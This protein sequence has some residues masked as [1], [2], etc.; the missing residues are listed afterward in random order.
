VTAPL[1]GITLVVTRPAAQAGHFIEL[2]NSLGARCIAFPTLEIEPLAADPAT[3]ARLCSHAWDWAIFTS[4]NAVDYGWAALA[5]T[6]VAR[7]AAVGRATARALEARG[8]DVDARPDSAN[9]EG[10]LALPEFQEVAGQRCVLVKG[11]GG[12]DL[13]QRELAARGA[14]VLELAVYRRRLAAPSR[15]AFEDLQLALR[16]PGNWIAVTSVEVLEALLELVGDESRASLLGSAL[17]VPGER[18]AAAA[19]GLGWRGPVAVARTAEDAA[20]VDALRSY[21]KGP[22]TTP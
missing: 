3:R 12:R 22:P 20:M 2:A 6:T 10:L 7:F 9:S 19:G 16:T 5:E 13:M 4:A 21:L 1:A 18:V 8:C 15:S 11:S 17:L 14:E